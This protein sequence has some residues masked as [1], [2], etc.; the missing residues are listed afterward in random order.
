MMPGAAHAFS[1]LIAAGGGGAWANA[2]SV[3]Y[4]GVDTA[5]VGR[6]NFGQPAA[7]S[8]T[9]NSQELTVTFWFRRNARD[10]MLFASRS[11]SNS[12]WQISMSGGAL[13]CYFGG[14]FASGGVVADA[15][16]YPVTMTVRN[17]SGTYVGRTYLGNSST[18]VLNANAGT[19][20][21]AMDFL[22]NLRRGSNN[23]N[24]SIGAWALSNIDELAIWNIGFTGTDHLEFRNGGTPMNPTTHSKAA[25]LISAYRCGDDAGDTAGTLNDVVGSNDGTHENTANVSYP[26]AVPP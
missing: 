1:K 7:W 20:A 17:E 10:G 4:A 13:V 3:R 25:N 11:D 12:Y 2:K 26:S 5:G 18:S 23:T 15:T 8:K 19:D 21:L 24:Y 22:L 16:W 6:T 14:N 9:L